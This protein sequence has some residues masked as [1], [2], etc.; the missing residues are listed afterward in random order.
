MLAK[1]MGTNTPINASL[2]NYFI[3]E[4]RTKALVSQFENNNPVIKNKEIS[5][6]LFGKNMFVSASR[7]E[8]YYN[9]AYRYFC[10]FGL[11]ARPLLAAQ[12]DS[13]QT[14]RLIHFVLEKIISEN[15]IKKLIEMR[16]SDISLIINSLIERYFAENIG[17]HED[18]S[19]RFNYRFLRL[20]KL[21][22]G[23]VMRLV[24]EFSQSDFEPVAFELPIDLDGA[25]E[26]PQIDIEG[27]GKITVRGSVDRVDVFCCDNKKYVRVID[28][29]SGSKE[30]ALSDVIQ[31]LNLQMF[32]YLF[33]VCNDKSCEFSGIP[34]GVLYMHS[35]RREYSADRRNPQSDIIKANNRE[36]RMKGIIL[37]D[38]DNK[39]SV[40]MEKGEQ[41][42][43]IPVKRKKDGLLS[44]NVATLA[45]LGML[46]RKVNSLIS[47]MGLELHEGKISQNPVNGKNHDKTCEFCDYSSVCLLRKEIFSRELFECDNEQAL[48]E[49]QKEE[50]DA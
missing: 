14:G 40:H 18:F 11:G 10:K 43:F 26:P 44:G 47:Q 49:L 16:E 46:S 15:T 38:D 13:M 32:I 9:C 1:T 37:D 3:S 35:S 19:A 7:V 6:E 39:I 12:M 28:Y 34:A 27:Y 50:N 45:E 8:D 25:V 48:I 2:Q 4:P 29:K 41:G 33:A 22:F 36:Y 17:A 5:Q 42:N 24:E 20:Q 31:G 23:I 30:F 21:L